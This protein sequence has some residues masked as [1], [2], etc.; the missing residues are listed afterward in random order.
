MEAEIIRSVV[1][2]LETQENWCGS[3]PNLKTWEPEALMVGS[4]SKN[5]QVW[6]P[7]SWC[8]GFSPKARKNWYSSSRAV[9]QDEFSLTHRGVTFFFHS[10]LQWVGWG[11]PTWGQANCVPQSTDSNVNLTLNPSQMHTHTQP[12]LTKCLALH[13]PVKLTH[14]INH[15]SRWDSIIRLNECW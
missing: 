6:H 8:F 4:Q 13:G 3:C 12:C 5:W 7:K 14:K 11:S 15:H 1:S 9:R 10:G 2:K